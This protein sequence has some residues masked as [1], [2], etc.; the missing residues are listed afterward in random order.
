MYFLR[1]N[2]N[3][4]KYRHNVTIVVRLKEKQYK[5]VSQLLGDK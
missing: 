4:I 3:L 2:A 1:K 5:I